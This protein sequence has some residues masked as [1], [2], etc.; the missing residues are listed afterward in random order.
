MTALDDDGSKILLFTVFHHCCTEDII[1]LETILVEPAYKQPIPHGLPVIASLANIE[2]YICVVPEEFLHDTDDGHLYLLVA[3]RSLLV[4]VLDVKSVCT[5]LP[6][7]RIV[8]KANFIDDT[9]IR[10]KE[11]VIVRFIPDLIRASE[12][13]LYQI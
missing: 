6:Y 2:K 12:I 4:G 8:A 7:R 10:D 1:L 9:M 11:I 13:Q 5:R 3:W